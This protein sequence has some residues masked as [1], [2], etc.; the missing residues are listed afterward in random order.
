MLQKMNKK[1]IK[2]V[3]IM[4]GILFLFFVFPFFFIP[5]PQITEMYPFKVMVNS[6]FNEDRSITLLGDNLEHIIAVYI[7]DVWEPDCVV[8]YTEEESVKLFLPMHYYQEAGN[9]KICLQTK[10]NGDIFAKSN[11]EILQVLSDENIGI[12]GIRKL[13]PQKLKFDGNIYQTIK[14]YGDNLNEDSVVYVEDVP[15]ETVFAEDHLEICMPYA[16]WHEKSLLTA[17]VVQYYDGYAT[18]VQSGNYSFETIRDENDEADE[19]LKNMYFL[20]EY[21]EALNND[22]YIVVMSVKDD[23]SQAMTEELVQRMHDLGL[24]EDLQQAG[25]RK[26]YLAVLDGKKKIFEDISDDPIEYDYVTDDI[27]L[28]AASANFNVGDCA[29]IQVNDVE[30]S[31]NQCGLNIVVYDKKLGRVVDSVS[32]NTNVGLS[33][34]ERLGIY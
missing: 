33:V 34:M 26:S 9:L 2:V 1:K 15:I 7:N 16:F 29:T 6:V 3:L 28:H 14:V 24:E 18:T 17:R 22:D 11:T 25:M 20:E 4:I 32:V 8:Q 21:M 31:M 27:V 12:P 19:F 30:Y 5:K 13:D 23:S 10:V